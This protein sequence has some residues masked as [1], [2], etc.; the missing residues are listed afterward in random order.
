MQGDDNHY[1]YDYYY[2]YSTPTIWIGINDISYEDC[3]CTSNSMRKPDFCLDAKT[4]A[5]ISCSVSVQLI[6]AFVFIAYI[7]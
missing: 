1:D 6:C 5:L 7:V 4:K 3:K 2:D